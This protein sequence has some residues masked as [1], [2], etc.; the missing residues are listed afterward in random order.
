MKTLHG[1]HLLREQEIKEL[2]IQATLFR[3]EKTG[4]ELLSLVNNDENKVFGITFRTPPADSTGVAS[5]EHP[6]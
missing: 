5:G 3:H 4:A 1:F 6:C 2:K